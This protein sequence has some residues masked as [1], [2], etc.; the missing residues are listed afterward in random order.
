M[1]EVAFYHLTETPL[2]AVLPVM[3]ERT[4]ARGAWAEVRGPDPRRLADLDQ[5][6][7]RFRD[8]SFLPHGL[9]S[10]PHA[11]RQP[12]LLTA[13]PAA[14]AGRRAFLFLLD[15]APFDPAEAPGR[16]RVALVFDGHDEAAVGEARAAWRTATGA[17]LA[18]VYW[19]Q[20]GGRWVRRSRTN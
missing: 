17:G 18:A 1:S 10:D 19:A 12:I 16:D 2:E 15:R 14:D 4:L 3:L 7:W 5:R 11:G 8:E 6:L 20:D 13:A 9:A